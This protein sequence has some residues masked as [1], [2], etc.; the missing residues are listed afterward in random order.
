MTKKSK[1]SGD[2]Q[3]HL[4]HQ[5]ERVL[6]EPELVVK[7]SEPDREKE[8]ISLG[9]PLFILKCLVL[10]DQNGPVKALP[11]EITKRITLV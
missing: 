3:E 8:Q 5:E 1:T 2:S 9:V 4:T 11:L 10:E 6:L 7:F